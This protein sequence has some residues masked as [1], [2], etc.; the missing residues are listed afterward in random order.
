MEVIKIRNQEFDPDNIKRED[1]K[2]LANA[3]E[4]YISELESVMII[5]DEI[6]DNCEDKIREGIKR[7][8]KLIKKLR[9]GDKDI[10]KDSDEWNFIS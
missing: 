9:N 5:P 10:F 4:D 3:I 6:L 7:S 1:M 8:R 2:K